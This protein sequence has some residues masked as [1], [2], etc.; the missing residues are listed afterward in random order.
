MLLM[1]KGNFLMINE[2]RYGQSW[3]IWPSPLSLSLYSTF[4]QRL[5]HIRSSTYD[6]TE[7]ELK[8][9]VVYKKACRLS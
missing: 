9:S 1:R 6:N 8:R 7:V 2:F 4:K 3:N 5:S